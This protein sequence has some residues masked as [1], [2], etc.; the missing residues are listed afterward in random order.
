MFF[1]DDKQS[2]VYNSVLDMIYL[3]D[4]KDDRII[5]RSSDFNSCSCQVDYVLKMD[6]S[7]FNNKLSCQ[8]YIYLGSLYE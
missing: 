4:I 2:I 6:F 1:I 5:L 7:D 3:A 8:D